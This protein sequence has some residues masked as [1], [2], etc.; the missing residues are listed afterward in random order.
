[1]G[2]Y[3]LMKGSGDNVYHHSEPVYTTSQL[4]KTGLFYKKL[5]TSYKDPTQGYLYSLFK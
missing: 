5:L 1:M 3:V 4:N 2:R